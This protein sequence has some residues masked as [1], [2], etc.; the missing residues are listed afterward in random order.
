MLGSETI[1]GLHKSPAHVQTISVH[2]FA[3]ITE[4]QNSYS[5]IPSDS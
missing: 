5:G 4:K 1:T 2:Q 3:Q